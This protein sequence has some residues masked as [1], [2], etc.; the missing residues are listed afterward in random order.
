MELGVDGDAM[1]SDEDLLRIA[2]TIGFNNGGDVPVGT[3]SSAAG[4]GSQQP[5]MAMGSSNSAGSPEH[6]S[7]RELYGNA[8]T[9]QDSSQKG[10]LIKHD[11]EGV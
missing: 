5:A 3:A 11:H 4:V 6:F 8:H 2:P 7:H 9:V 1:W 10:F